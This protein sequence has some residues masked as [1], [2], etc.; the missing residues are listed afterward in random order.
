MQAA[1][2]V[3]VGAVRLFLCQVR[4]DVCA[5]ATQV[6]PGPPASPVARHAGI[7]AGVVGAQTVFVLSIDGPV[8]FPQVC[9]AVV[10]SNAVNVVDEYLWP[11][12][13]DMEP[14]EAMRGVA[15]P[16]QPNMAVA[17]W[18]SGAASRLTYL[19]SLS[20]FFQPPKLAGRWVVRQRFS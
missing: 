14:C 7:P 15:S 12:S 11:C 13:I 4:A 8:C 6:D 16:V 9:D 20:G 1:L 19:D 3:K 18:M 2:S 5:L 10:V 17:A